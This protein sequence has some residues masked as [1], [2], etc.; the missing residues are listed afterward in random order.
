MYRDPLAAGATAAAKRQRRPRS[1]ERGAAA[2]SERTVNAVRRILVEMAFARNPVACAELLRLDQERVYLFGD[3]A[4][5]AGGSVVVID[6][7]E[8]AG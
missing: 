8:V 7:V 5:A 6:P 2:Q 3:R 4:D 1:R